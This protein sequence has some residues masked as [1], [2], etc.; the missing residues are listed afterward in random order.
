MFG[1]K[2]AVDSVL[3][4][5]IPNGFRVCYLAIYAYVTRG[6]SDDLPYYK[7]T[8]SHMLGSEIREKTI[9]CCYIS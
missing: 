7:R 8:D 3:L 1:M 6:W 9:E 2:T 5:R 4:E